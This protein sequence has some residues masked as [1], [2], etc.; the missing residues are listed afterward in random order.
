MAGTGILLIKKYS[1]IKINKSEKINI[2]PLYFV[3][4]ALNAKIYMICAARKPIMPVYS[5]ILL[6]LTRNISPHQEKA[7]ASIGATEKEAE[8]KR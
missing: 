2:R 5:Q 4:K 8:L 3:I 7:I 6:R 1:I